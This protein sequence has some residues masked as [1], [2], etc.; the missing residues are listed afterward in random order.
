VLPRFP[1]A[2]IP[3]PLPRWNRWVHSS[4]ASP[5]IAAFPVLWPGRLPHQ[6][7]R[8][9]HG[10]RLPLRS[11]CSPSHLRDPLH[12]RLR[13]LRF[14]HDR[15]DCYR[16][17]RKLPGGTTSHWGTAP[18]H[19]AP[20][21]RHTQSELGAFSSGA[22]TVKGIGVTRQSSVPKLFQRPIAALTTASEREL[23]FANSICELDTCKR[24][25]RGSE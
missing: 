7:F 11:A 10:V 15:S 22:L 21:S 24:D 13:P 16:P 23:P 14:L 18:F 25:G 6:P 12:R 5:A 4:L 8:G 20:Q 3:P 19:G 1:C 17:E 2:H 9:L